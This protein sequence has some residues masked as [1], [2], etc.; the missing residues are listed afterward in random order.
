MGLFMIYYIMMMSRTKRI[1]TRRYIMTLSQLVEL[2]KIGE[3]AAARF[4]GEVWHVKKTE[5]HQIRYYVPE[6]N[7][8]GELV[9]LAYSNLEAEYEILS[10]GPDTY[11]I[12]RE[13][14]VATGDSGTHDYMGSCYGENFKDACINFAKK[15][16]EFHKY[17]D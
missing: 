9:Q 2:L 11:N 10:K 1:I 15:D 13:G 17:F 5:T 12:W 6:T 16:L 3:V 14:Y 7:S 4:G 8:I